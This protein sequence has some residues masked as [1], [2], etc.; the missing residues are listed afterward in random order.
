MKMMRRF[1]YLAAI[2]LMWGAGQG[3]K[4]T[5]ENG[6]SSQPNDTTEVQVPDQPI[7]PV[8][9]TLGTK[10]NGGVDTV[11]NAVSQAASS[12]FPPESTFSQHFANLQKALF[13]TAYEPDALA[14]HEKMPFFSNSRH[15][16]FQRM[17]V[18]KPVGTTAGSRIYPR[19]T[20]K[21]YQF[22]NSAEAQKTVVKWLND[23]EHSGD[24]LQLG[25][26]VKAIKS[27]PVLV[28]IK[29]NEVFMLQTACMYTEGDWERIRGVFLGMAKEPTVQY[30]FSIG[31]NAGELTYQKP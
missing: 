16:M 23:F 10:E 24:S 11:A 31:C 8:A 2:L 21:G 5:P 28:A 9:D 30:V 3:C 27:P 13:E 20:F 4:E 18:R 26:P 1:L 12:L 7:P 25:V 17:R 19:H 14:E 6:H 29:D 15:K 22:S